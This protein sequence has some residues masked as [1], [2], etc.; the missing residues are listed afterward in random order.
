MAGSAGGPP[1]ASRV[2]T[3]LT[4]VVVVVGVIPGSELAQLSGELIGSDGSTRSLFGVLGIW[5]WSSRDAWAVW[6]SSPYAYLLLRLV[7][8]YV[9]AVGALVAAGVVLV[10]RFVAGDRG[11]GAA[12]VSGATRVVAVAAVVAGALLVAGAVVVQHAHGGNPVTGPGWAAPWPLADGVA[13][14]ATVGWAAGLVGVLAVLRTGPLR[15]RV[16]DG[17]VRLARALYYQRL[18]FLVV[19]L[20]AA[21]TV[22]PLPDIFDQLPDVERAWSDL[23]RQAWV[24]LGAALLA[25]TVVTVELF[26]VGR[27]RSRRARQ[28]YVHQR[29]LD[30]ERPS[31]WWLTAPVMVL[32]V[33]VAL[34]AAGRGGDVDWRAWAIFVAVP[35]VLWG[36]SW[37]LRAGPL[38][39]RVTWLVPVPVLPNEES[40]EYAVQKAELERRADDVRLAGD[41]LALGVVLV[42]GLGLVRSFVT[43]VVLGPAHRA[44]LPWQWLLELALLVLGLSATLLAVPAGARLTAW[45]ARPRQGSLLARLRPDD[46]HQ[47]VGV[48]AV[49]FW[50]LSAVILLA[51][52]FVPFHVAD[53]LGVVATVALLAAA[54]AYQLGFLQVWLQRSQPLEV[55]R[56]V[57]L[58]ATPVISTALLVLVVNSLAGGAPG[59][60]AVRAAAPAPGGVSQPEL[61]AALD[62]WLEHSRTCDLTVTGAAGPVRVH[63]MLLV[64]ADGGGIRAA[65]WTAHAL[66]ALAAAGPCGP[67]S[68][69]LSSGVSGGSVGL[70]LT[71]G[72]DPAGAVSRLADP[73]ALALAA[74]GLLVGDLLAATAGL[75]IPAL[76]APGGARWLDRAGKMEVAWEGEAPVLSTRFSASPQGPAGVLELNT[77]A[78]GVSCRALVGQADLSPAQPVAPSTAPQH[79]VRTD[80]PCRGLDA[81]AAATFDLQGVYGRC[82]PGFTWSTAAM[83]SARFPYVTPSGRVP[84]CAGAGE[85]QLIDGGYAEG[86]GVGLL[87]ES[88]AALMTAVRAVNARIVPGSRAA[89]LVPI[90]VY[91]RN[92]N[93]ADLAAPPASLTSETVVPVV[94]RNAQHLQEDTGTWLQRA[95][96]A[97][98]APCPA[99]ARADEAADPAAACAAAATAVRQHLTGGIVLVAPATH[100]GAATPLGWTLSAES[101]QRLRSALHDE[102]VC[103]PVDRQKDPDHLAGYARLCLLLRMLRSAAPG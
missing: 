57:R 51:E 17:V 43:P 25:M 20:L 88:A 79:V 33:A 21:L 73:R 68:V 99:P 75:R 84:A 12:V 55:F 94:G 8:L 60:H 31:W 77:T 65:T 10:R 96:D 38:P 26:V 35:T 64:A 23:T 7:L 95:S 101:R 9:L 62:T 91:L 28:L 36:V 71:R 5:P 34:I 47:N 45:I 74:G 86:S 102:A 40:A 46:P 100:P 98:A 70:A 37:T 49:A 85:L 11:V 29:E 16:G 81:P 93:G 30:D 4:W 69:F 32:A 82:L 3:G 66:A 14:A 42:A 103:T 76:D 24:H 22:V 1:G 41:G 54:W 83:L 56:A 39:V 63:P 97:L 90:V 92:S 15:C 44:T 89:Y 6:E 2:A 58:H 13:A 59:L 27:L 87:G 72:P 50:C 18:A 80:P 19:A 61:P 78:A 52:A 48:V 53:Y 67:S